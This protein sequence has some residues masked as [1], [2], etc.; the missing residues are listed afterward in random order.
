MARRIRAALLAQ[1]VASA[2]IAPVYS[3]VLLSR[4]V[5]LAV[6]SLCMAAQMVTVVALEVPSGVLSDLLGRRRLFVSACLAAAYALAY[7]VTGAGNVMDSSVVQASVPNE[8]RASVSSLTSLCV[9]GGGLAL[10]AVG[11]L[12]IGALG[13]GGAWVVFGALAAAVT[14]VARA[15]R[16]LTSQKMAR[17]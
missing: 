7:L 1:A 15:A 5:T 9:R 4:G 13:L 16:S 17:A 3:L 10:S 11:P 14:L 12:A 8:Q 6:L 2:L